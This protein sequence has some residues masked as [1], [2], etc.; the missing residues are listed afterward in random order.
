MRPFTTGMA[1]TTYCQL[2]E[3]K[4]PLQLA[5]AHKKYICIFPIFMLKFTMGLLLP[6]IKICFDSFIYFHFGIT[7]Y[8]YHPSAFQSG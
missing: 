3:P 4:C 2:I 7:I 1:F 5:I 8:T 6:M